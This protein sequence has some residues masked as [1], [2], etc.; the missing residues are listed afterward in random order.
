MS[1]KSPHWHLGERDLFAH[2]QNGLFTIC[3]VG[4]GLASPLWR[5][6]GERAHVVL[7]IVFGEAVVVI[8]ALL[9]F[10]EWESHSQFMFMSALGICMCVCVSVCLCVCVFVCLC[11]W[12][13]ICV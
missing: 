12:V 7:C 2:D 9:L 10:I 13:G 1:L 11:A 5:S 4:Q 6:D 8:V 3:Q